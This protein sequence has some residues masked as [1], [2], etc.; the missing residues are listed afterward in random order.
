[1]VVGHL[2]RRLVPDHG[3]RGAAAVARA[4]DESPPLLG[5]DAR[6]LPLLPVFLVRARRPALAHLRRLPRGDTRGAL[7]SAGGGCNPCLDGLPRDGRARAAAP[8]H[9]FLHRRR[10]ALPPLL[11]ALAHRRLAHARAAGDL[12]DVPRAAA[13]LEPP[14][15]PPV[16]RLPPLQASDRTRGQKGGGCKCKYARWGGSGITHTQPVPRLTDASRVSCARSAGLS[17]LFNGDHHPWW[18]WMDGQSMRFYFDNSRLEVPEPFYTFTMHYDWFAIAQCAGSVAFE[19]STPL[20]F[21]TPYRLVFPLLGALAR[22]ASL[23]PGAVLFAALLG[24]VSRSFVAAPLW[25]PSC[26]CTRP[27]HPSCGRSCRRCLRRRFPRCDLVHA[28]RQLPHV[29]HHP[30]DA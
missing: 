24:A 19:L 30:M 8:H 16:E 14:D 27:L 23:D 26:P 10:L 13:A 28:R 21:W 22:P 7:D 29:G 4:C 6:H 18:A 17:K 15:D 12:H 5:R 2:R 11:R 3:R 20:V 25:S 1:M 9:G